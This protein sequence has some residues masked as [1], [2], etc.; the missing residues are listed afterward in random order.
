MGAYHDF[1]LQINAKQKRAKAFWCDTET[2]WIPSPYWKTFYFSMPL[3]SYKT[4]YCSCSGIIGSCS[5]STSDASRTLLFLSTHIP[6]VF[7]P[8]A[9]SHNRNLSS[10]A[11]LADIRC[12]LTWSLAGMQTDTF[13]GWCSRVRNAILK[14]IIFTWMNISHMRHWNH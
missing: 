9:F 13:G 14:C 1:V 4:T 3:L 6:F 8:A 2:F 12:H 7:H 5:Y 10:W 11:E